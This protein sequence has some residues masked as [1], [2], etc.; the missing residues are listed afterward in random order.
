[1]INS[2]K[3]S[4]TIGERLKKQREQLGLTLI[5]V[6]HR[7][8]APPQF[9][10]ALEEDD[11]KRFPAKVYAL[12]FFKRL[13]QE[14]A[15]PDSEEW[16]KGFNNE[17]GVRMFR[18]TKEAVPLPENRGEE[19]YITPARL[20]TGMGILLFVVL[21]IFL[22]LRFTNFVTMPELNLEMPR[23]QEVLEKPAVKIKGRTEKESQLTVN[24]RGIKID[25]QGN[26]E[27]DI[28]LVTGLNTLEFRTQNRFGKES[29]VVRHVLVR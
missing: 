10:Q 14:L 29:K 6:A 8:Q 15:V 26:F 4:E 5:E 11:Y 19:P 2:L 18:K 24:G 16:L 13:L 1:M 20:W 25:G 22:S 28:E 12:G 27:E 3:K 7:I 21:L 17:W 23:E 9:V